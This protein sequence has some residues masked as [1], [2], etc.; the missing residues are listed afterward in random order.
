MRSM[1]T[2]W[3]ISERHSLKLTQF[4]REFII[5]G[6]SPCITHNVPHILQDP[7]IS[8]K[9]HIF[10]VALRRSTRVLGSHLHVDSIAKTHQYR[11]CSAHRPWL[12]GL[13]VPLCVVSFPGQ[14]KSLHG[15]RV[16]SRWRDVHP[17]SEGWQ[18]QVSRLRERDFR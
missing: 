10:Q 14:L 3:R 7:M 2:P 11:F 16:R 4:P 12:C 15:P 1:T 13:P 5:G 6:D 8:G 9:V 18:V 17:S